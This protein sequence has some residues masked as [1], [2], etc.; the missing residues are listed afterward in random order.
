MAPRS[1]HD[2]GVSLGHLLQALDAFKTATADTLKRLEVAVTRIETNCSPCGKRLTSL[3]HVT[4][5]TN[6][7]PGL[8]TDVDRLKTFRDG[9]VEEHKEQAE[10]SEK[11]RSEWRGWQLAIMAGVFG[12]VAA[13][14][15][16]LPSVARWVWE[17]V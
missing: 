11:A 1:E 3:E 16:V 15:E 14:V 8:K 4:Y 13:L 17:K 10:A 5:G 2:D 9:H 12:V 7:T 6:G